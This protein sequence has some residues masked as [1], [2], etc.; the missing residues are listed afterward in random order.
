MAQGTS[1]YFVGFSHCF[2][3]LFQGGGANMG[4]DMGGKIVC[5]AYGIYLLILLVNSMVSFWQFW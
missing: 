1:G 4:G 5:V 3:F 2:H